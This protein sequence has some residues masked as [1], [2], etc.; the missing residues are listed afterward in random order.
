VALQEV[1]GAPPP[2]IWPEGWHVVYRD[3]YLLA[4]RYPI[5]EAGSALRT[6]VAN[7]HIGFR[8][9]IQFPDRQVQFFNLH[10]MTP[11]SGLEAVL[12]RRSGL[13]LSGIPML[14]A[15]L[16][17]RE[18]ETRLASDW[19]ASFPDAKIVAGDFNMPVD[20]TIYRDYWTWLDNAFSTTGFGFG[21]TKMTEKQGWT[22]GARIDQILY[23]PPWTCVRAW[24]ASDI[25]SDHLPLVA[26]FQ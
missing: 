7:K 8:Y 22:Y 14:E 21:F 6:T 18:A 23:S 24:V 3:E 20:S 26:D 19:V 16:R 12:D 11:R 10:L 5:V 13:D 2:L 9:L 15:I 1:R 25:G 17:V 4:S